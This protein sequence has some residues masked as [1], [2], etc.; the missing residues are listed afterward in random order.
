M[1]LNKSI[2][3]AAMVG[4][5]IFLTYPKSRDVARKMIGVFD[6]DGLYLVLVHI[7]MHF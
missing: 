2:I 5:L 4:D 3:M 1:L 7:F 6:F